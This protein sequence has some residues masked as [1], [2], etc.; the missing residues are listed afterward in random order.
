[1]KPGDIVRKIKGFE[2][3]AF[4]GIEEVYLW[5]SVSRMV[6]SGIRHYRRFCVAE[7]S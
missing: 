3:T 1:M 5:M 4:I 2:D 7:L 6:V